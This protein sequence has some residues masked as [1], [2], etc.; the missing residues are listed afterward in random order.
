MGHSPPGFMSRSDEG[1]G[2]G[3]SDHRHQLTGAHVPRRSRGT[4]G[5][6]TRI[7]ASGSVTDTASLLNGAHRR[8]SRHSTGPLAAYQRE[9]LPLLK[10]ADARAQLS[11]NPGAPAAPTTERP[12]PVRLEIHPAQCRSRYPHLAVACRR[13]LPPRQANNDIGALHF[14]PRHDLSSLSCCEDGRTW[15]LVQAPSRCCERGPGLHRAAEKFLSKATLERRRLPIPCRSGLDGCF[16]A[17]D[18][19]GAV[20]PPQARPTTP[21]PSSTGSA[22]RDVL[23]RQ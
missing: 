12:P 3:G 17:D 15:C 21:V 9:V 19:S 16:A 18:D 1:V 5:S 20:A 8:S 6:R 10:W 13:P 14:H 7:A 4:S 22:G 2:Q 23:L 11:R